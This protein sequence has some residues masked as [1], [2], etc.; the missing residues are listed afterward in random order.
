MQSG[1]T[2]FKL[3]WASRLVAA[4]Q[5]PWKGHRPLRLLW[6]IFTYNHSGIKCRYGWLVLAILRRIWEV[7]INRVV[8]KMLN[9]CPHSPLWKLYTLKGMNVWHHGRLR[10]E[11]LW[12]RCGHLSETSIY[13]GCS[14]RWLIDLYV[15]GWTY[16]NLTTV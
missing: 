2:N 6:I 9:Y 14:R 12:T 13:N 5:N 16:R 7:V 10:V 3:I 4:N 15:N 8:F 11:V 1:T